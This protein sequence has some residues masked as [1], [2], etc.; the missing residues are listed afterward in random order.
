VFCG[1][2]STCLLD[3]ERY[4]DFTGDGL[5][6]DSFE[7]EDFKVLSLRSSAVLRWE[8]RPGSVLFLV[9]QQARRDQLD[10]ADFNLGS[11]LGDVF[12][13]SGEDTFIAKASFYVDF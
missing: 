1:S 6:D 2:G 11:D 13:A 3:G 9:W 7:D 12:S 5:A 10:N 4:V 8:Y